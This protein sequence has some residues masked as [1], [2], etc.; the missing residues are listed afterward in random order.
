MS[1]ISL[2]PDAIS[3]VLRA[4]LVIVIPVY[5]EAVTIRSVVLEW[6]QILTRL[7]IDYQFLLLNDGSMDNTLEVLREI[8][9]SSPANLVVV[10]KPNS[11]HGRTC[12]LGYDAATDASSVEW[13]LQIDSDGQC[14]PSY[15]EIFWT[16]RDKA[17]CIFGKR[18]KRD[19][20]FARML[21]SKLCKIGSSILGGKDLGDPNVPYRLMRKQILENALK[22]IPASFNIHNV[23]LTYILKRTDGVRW[24]F[25]PIRFRQRQGGS[26][27]INL[28]N[29]AQWGV[30]M[31]LELRKLRPKKLPPVQGWAQKKR[32]MF[33]APYIQSEDKVL[34]I[35]CASGWVRSALKERGINN[36]TGLDI[37][38]PADI[39]GDI[40]NWKEL[41]LKP[42]SFDVIVAF[43]VVEYVDCFQACYDLLRPGGKMLITTPVP[44][45]DWILSITE[46][47]G[48]NQKRTSP[49][50]HLV[51][52]KKIQLFHKKEI[53]IIL[54]L[55]QWA[56]FFK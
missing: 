29:V 47:L 51:R 39:V 53:R 19:D 41:D 38:P 32:M 14:D 30:D 21:T 26:N 37:S 36:Y 56:I 22:E 33:F 23:A 52:L 6:T 45:T 54:G 31:L 7:K 16:N 5:N 43:E 4:P 24:E 9:A 27:S 8:E 48:L 13:I 18:I 11:G 3:N 10:D 35:G 12:R 20:G 42:C 28:L 34:E 1:F 46:F 50:N 40:N 55:G 2:R 44:G 49:H 17:D 15:F 25:V